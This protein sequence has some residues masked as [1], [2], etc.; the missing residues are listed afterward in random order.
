MLSY[1]Y[2]VKLTSDKEMAINDGKENYEMAQRGLN[3]STN[4]PVWQQ[5]RQ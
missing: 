4:N 5:R 3:P 1:L 2:V